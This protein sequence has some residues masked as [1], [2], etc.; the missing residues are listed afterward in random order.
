[1]IIVNKA[2]NTKELTSVGSFFLATK[3][4]IFYNKGSFIFYLAYFMVE[5]YVLYFYVLWG[6]KINNYFIEL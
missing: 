3:H 4:G 1:M 2:K 5:F 6:I